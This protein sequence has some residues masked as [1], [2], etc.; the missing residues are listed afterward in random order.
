[1]TS[2][3]L[4]GCR[5]VPNWASWGGRSDPYAIKWLSQGSTTD[6]YSKA[7]TTHLDDTVV[8]MWV[9]ATAQLANGINY[10]LYGVYNS[11][12]DIFSLELVGSTANGNT[13]EL[14]HM[15]TS[16]G[17]MI[18]LGTNWHNI[19]IRWISGNTELWVDGVIQLTAAGVTYTGAI[20]NHTIGVTNRPAPATAKFLDMCIVDEIAYFDAPIDPV[21]IYNSG[22]PLQYSNTYLNLIA[23]Y[24]VEKATGSITPNYIF[25]TYYPA[26]QPASF[27][28]GSVS[29]TGK[30]E[31]TTESL[32]S[33]DNNPLADMATKYGD[34]V[35]GVTSTALPRTPLGSGIDM[36]VVACGLMPYPAG[37]GFSTIGYTGAF[38]GNKDEPD[39]TPHMSKT[40]TMASGDS[41]AYAASGGTDSL[42]GVTD[43]RAGRL[44][45]P[46]FVK[47]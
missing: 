36:T 4:R 27:S 34:W 38:I 19:T 23:S 7:A 6:F 42:T 25:P 45:L 5:Q 20:T 43:A 13:L 2:G 10:G 17:T 47:R 21:V 22:V 24:E 9:K 8:T 33:S 41:T 1:M 37:G 18:G 46:R 31:V 12:S 35:Y 26:A 32:R 3:L 11:P 15:G 39:A 30:V 40:T 28:W 44:F 29:T 16:L 14:F